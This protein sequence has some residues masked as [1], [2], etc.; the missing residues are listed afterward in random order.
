MGQRR[1][2]KAVLAALVI[3]S[4]L[5]ASAQSQTW[6]VASGSGD[7][8]GYIDT[9]SIR[10]EGD[11]V[12]FWREVRFATPRTFESG[13]RYDRLGA[14]M[15]FD[16]RARTRATLELYAKFG[17]GMVGSGSTTGPVEP[18]TEGSTAHSELRAVCFNEW[19]R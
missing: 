1:F 7:R 11:K 19:P 6:R 8:T 10:R 4:A 9:A 13:E 15:E 2:V 17:D 18:I 3:A 14:H 5:P 16:C 12:R